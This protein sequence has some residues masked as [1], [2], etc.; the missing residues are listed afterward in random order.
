VVMSARVAPLCCLPSGSLHV[1]QSYQDSVNPDLNGT[2]GPNLQKQQGWGGF[3][4]IVPR[5]TI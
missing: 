4:E 5:E 1:K 2:G 3:I